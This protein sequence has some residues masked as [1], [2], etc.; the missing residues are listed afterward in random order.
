MGLFDLLPLSG[1][2][3]TGVKSFVGQQRPFFQDLGYGL[4]KGKNWQE[5][6]EEA[7][8]RSETMAP[9]RSREAERMG[10]IQQQQEQRNQTL[11]WLSQNHP[12]LAQMVNSG[13]PVGD[14][15]GQALKRMQQAGGGDASFGLTPIWGVGPDGQPTIGQLSNQGGLQPVQMPD[16]FQFGK[17][18]IRM[19]AGDHFVL[20]D[21]VTRQQIGM[22]P[23]NGDV[24]TGFQQAPGGGVAPMPGSEQDVERQQRAAKAGSAMTALEQKNA[25]AINAIDTALSQANWGTTGALGAIGSMPGMW[26]HDLA[27][28]LDT[29]KANIGFEELNT[30]RENSPT[31][32]AL[33]Q[34]T[35]RELAFLQSTIASIEQ[36]QSEEQLKRNLQILRDF[37]AA[38]QE[39][40][41][42]AYEQQFGG[43]GRGRATPSAPPAAQG[44]QAGPAAPG[45]VDPLG[46]RF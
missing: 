23:K 5:G 39:R 15:W 12:D 34:I 18:P 8:K 26:A 25:V 30:M 27:K 38:S 14:A 6:M 17:D 44:G 22:I 20:L 7:A 32:G 29:V 35:E 16:G 24:P 33:G 11:E 9:L 1:P 43:S 31:G 19:D 13:M 42:A 28:T 40:R 21:P 3:G 36:S 46:L 41:R 37:I 45:G 2:I 10:E 4:M